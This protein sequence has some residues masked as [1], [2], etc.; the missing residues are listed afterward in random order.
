MDLD[1][2]KRIYIDSKNDKERLEMIAG[3]LVSQEMGHSNLEWEEIRLIGKEKIKWLRN[4]KFIV[5][6]NKKYG[7]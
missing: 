6:Y 3:Y 1:V 7:I 2:F 5:D 4:V